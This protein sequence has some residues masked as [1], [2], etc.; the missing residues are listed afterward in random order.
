MLRLGQK[1]T[2]INVVADQFGTPTYA[3]D[4]ALII[5][6]ILPQLKNKTVAIYHYTNE[7]SCNWAEFAVEIFSWEES[8]RKC[9]MKIK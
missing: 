6:E 3:R 1:R 9:L 2:E 5:L 4:L 8:L 7:G